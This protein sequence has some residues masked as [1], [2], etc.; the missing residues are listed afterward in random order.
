MNCPSESSKRLDGCTR[1]IPPGSR[2][3]HAAHGISCL[4][5]AEEKAAWKLVALGGEP[6]ARGYPS[7][8]MAAPYSMA[9]ISS[10][11][12]SSASVS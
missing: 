2:P 11:W 10:R 3:R 5:W 6:D 9:S 12:Q 4:G 7:M 1:F 8:T